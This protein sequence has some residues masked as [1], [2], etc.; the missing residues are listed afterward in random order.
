LER[1]KAELHEDLNKKMTEIVEKSEELAE[2]ADQI[3]A[4]LTELK[5]SRFLN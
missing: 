5:E 4:L 2:K 3:N 1:E